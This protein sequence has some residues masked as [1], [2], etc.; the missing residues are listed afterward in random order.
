MYVTEL[1]QQFI[2][3]LFLYLNKMFNL[4]YLFTENTYSPS[5]YEKDLKHLQN[6][7]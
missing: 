3:L 5:I 2:H 4:V 1:K 6:A 7:K